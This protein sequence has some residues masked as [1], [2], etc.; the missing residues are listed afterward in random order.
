MTAILIISI[1]ASV[2][3]IRFLGSTVFF[4]CI[5]LVILIVLICFFYPIFR[6]EGWVPDLSKTP[7]KIWKKYQKLESKFFKWLD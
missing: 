1:I 6:D 4:W 3:I 7:K 5:P 2:L